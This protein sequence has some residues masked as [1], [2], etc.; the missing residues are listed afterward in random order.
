MTTTATERRV[1]FKLG[2]GEYSRDVAGETF[3]G[4][5]FVLLDGD[6]NLMKGAP[7]EA[8]GY[9]VGKLFDSPD[10]YVTLQ[11]CIT[12]EVRRVMKE[13]GVSTPDDFRIEQYHTLVDGAAHNEVAKKI[14]SGFS[15]GV[16]PFPVDTIEKRVSALLG[17]PVVCRYKKTD[18]ERKFNLRIVRPSSNDN[19]PPHRDVWLDH[20]RDAVNIYI[21]IAGSSKESSLPVVPGSHHW[22]ESEIERTQS[23]AR[24]GDQ[25]FMVPCVTAAKREVHFVRPNPGPN[26]LLVFSPYLIHGGG[27]NFQGTA[28]RASLE[29]RFW[30]A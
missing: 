25:V 22:K 5:D 29:A 4:G 11:R 8:Q 3:F 28:T 14:Q 7:Y 13:V 18:A 6:D 26:E 23:G 24:M 17:T 15:M 12:N 2:D 27:V 9:T 10:D 1:T 19:N 21:P 16:F 30:R 20:L